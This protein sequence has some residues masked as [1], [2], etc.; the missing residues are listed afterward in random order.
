MYTYN[1]FFLIF[2]IKEDVYDIRYY[3]QSTQL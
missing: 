1:F 2:E 3:Y